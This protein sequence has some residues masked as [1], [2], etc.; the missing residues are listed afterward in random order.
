MADKQINLKE[1]SDLDLGAVLAQQIEQLVLAQQNVVLLKEEMRLRQEA[2]QKPK[3]DIAAL[4][5][6][7]MAAKAE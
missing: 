1:L 3:D 4:K 2:A 6:K 5:E 7:L